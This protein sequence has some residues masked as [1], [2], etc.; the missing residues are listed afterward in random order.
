MPS[1]KQHSR[2]RVFMPQRLPV[3]GSDE[4]L[5]VIQEFASKQGMNP[6][7]ILSSIAQY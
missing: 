5:Q 7:A 3:K 4:A 1:T 2:D 6:I